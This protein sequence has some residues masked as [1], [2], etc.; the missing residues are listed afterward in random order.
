MAVAA[1][2]IGVIGA[3]ESSVSDR[4]GRRLSSGVT[5]PPI[6]GGSVRRHAVGMHGLV[7]FVFVRG[8]ARL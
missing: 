7:L 4:L 5:I 2:I 1:V 8:P 3:G 6:G